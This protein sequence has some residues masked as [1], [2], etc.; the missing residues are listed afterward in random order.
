MFENVVYPLNLSQVYGRHPWKHPKGGF[1]R[2]QEEGKQSM[3]ISVE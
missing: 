1:R 3:Q 2:A